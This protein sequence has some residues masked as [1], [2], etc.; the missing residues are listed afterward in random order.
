LEQ[1]CSW[2]G[3]VSRGSPSWT[4]RATL[5][6]DG[7]E[8]AVRKSNFLIASLVRKQETEALNPEELSTLRDLL[9]KHKPDR[10]KK[11]PRSR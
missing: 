4:H 5:I 10:I 7:K 2:R 8:E 1:D 3:I 9:K 6:S 11:K